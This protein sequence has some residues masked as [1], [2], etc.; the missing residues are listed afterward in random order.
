ML[1]FKSKP[2]PAKQPFRGHSFRATT[3]LALAAII[4]LLPGSAARAEDSP[5][6]GKKGKTEEPKVTQEVKDYDDFFENKSAR[7]LLMNGRREMQRRNYVRALKLMQEAVK[8]DPNDI[9]AQC[10]YAEAMQEKLKHQADKDPELFNKCVQLWLKIMR[11]EIGEE[12][13]LS[14]K[15][16]SLDNG[17]FG[18]EERVQRAKV[19]LK[20]LTGYVPKPWETNDHFLKRVLRNAS[21]SVSAQIKLPASTPE[22]GPATKPAPPR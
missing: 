19:E 8:L 9:D 6:E 20:A 11:S 2:T 18:D 21:T 1:L 4:W 14:Y 22:Q 5:Q 7:T 15:G 3:S 10:V 13:G 12:K 17:L 16:L